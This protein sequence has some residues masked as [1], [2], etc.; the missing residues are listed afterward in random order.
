MMD[1]TP[2]RSRRLVLKDHVGV[3][4]VNAFA[5]A[6]D[7]TV[8]GTIERSPE[9]GVFFEKKWAAR[10]GLS[11]HY[12]VDEFLGE[13]YMMAMSRH[14]DPDLELAD[15]SAG[16]DAWSRDEALFLFD[17]SV[18]GADKERAVRLLA[19]ISP[20]SADQSIVERVTK[21]S[22]SRHKGVRLAAI[23]AMA[24]ADWPEYRATLA[25]VAARDT[26]EEIRQAAESILEDWK[27]PDPP[28]PA[29]P[30]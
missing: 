1:E 2:H 12:I 27:E 4:D 6:R 28:S 13:R 7:W 17:A 19:A 24:Y 23:W 5:A 16:L 15:L 14:G 25:S 22:E 9:K 18:Y 21:A 26:E 8:L 30:A 29:P 11:V 20:A 10:A 3:A